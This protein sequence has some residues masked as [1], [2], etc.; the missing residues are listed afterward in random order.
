MESE[1]YVVEVP[2]GL[3]VQGKVERTLSSR[4]YSLHE[5]IERKA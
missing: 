2:V 5:Q 1:R 4:T 3:A